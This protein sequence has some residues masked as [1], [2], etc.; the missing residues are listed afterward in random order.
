MT[1]SRPR[2]ARA[3]RREVEQALE[4]NGW[5]WARRLSLWVDA[6]VVI[7]EGDG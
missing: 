3:A 4:A 5:P 6:L 2:Q 1:S 7:E